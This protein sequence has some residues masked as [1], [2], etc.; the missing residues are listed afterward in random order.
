M[1]KFLTSDFEF[2]KQWFVD[3]RSLA[4][5]NLSQAHLMQH[6]QMAENTLELAGINN[7]SYAAHS[8]I[9]PTDTVEYH[10]RTLTGKKYWVSNAA[11]AD[12]GI[13]TVKGFDIVY[14]PDL[15]L[16]TEV[17]LIPTSGMEETSTAD[18]EFNCT[19]A[20]KL[21]NK[22]DAGV[23]QL[24]HILDIGFVTNQLGVAEGLYKNTNTSDPTVELQL[25]ALNLLWESVL[26]IAELTAV[27]KEKQKQIDTVYAFAKFTLI[28]VLEYVLK[29]STSGLYKVDNTMHQL[30][31]DALI[32]SFHGR[33]LQKSL[34]KEFVIQYTK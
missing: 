22:S 25:N 27:D 24:F 16:S 31:K 26:P 19:P 2:K 5:K 30:Y 10:D 9:K 34:E 29:S 14:V 1:T 4:G 23:A 15:K 13:F 32:Y 28:K 18:I 3:L 20:V 7:N 21:F 6:Q 33:N 17:T 8:H 12:Y 11:N